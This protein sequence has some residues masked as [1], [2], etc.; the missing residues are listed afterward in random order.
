MGEL[1]V[2]T[3]ILV[4]TPRWAAA[5]HHLELREIP[6]RLMV[7]PLRHIS[8]LTPPALESLGSMAGLELPSR[9]RQEPQ[10]DR[11]LISAVLW[12]APLGSGLG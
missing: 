1:H 10:K 4:E 7:A 6:M 11:G 3:R 9:D 12:S 2:G 8:G 5:P